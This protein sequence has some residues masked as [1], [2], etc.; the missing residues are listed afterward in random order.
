MARSTE[1]MSVRSVVVDVRAG[2]ATVRDV[3]DGTGTLIS[4]AP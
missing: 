1:F 2:R 3:A 4:H